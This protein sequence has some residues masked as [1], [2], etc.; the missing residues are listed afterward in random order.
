MD[1]PADDGEVDATMASLMAETFG[2]ADGDA[3]AETGK[4]RVERGLD[5]I[6]EMTQ[7]QVY[8]VKVT[9]WSGTMRFFVDNVEQG[10]P[11]S[12]DAHL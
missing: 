7:D 4:G 5:Q 12:Q 8:T 3:Q 10:L 11:R 9:L 6:A 1:L 2:P